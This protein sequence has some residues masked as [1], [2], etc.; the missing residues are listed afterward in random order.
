MIIYG[1]GGMWVCVLQVS[2]IKVVAIVLLRLNI[3]CDAGRRAVV[4]VRQVRLASNSKNKHGTSVTNHLPQIFFTLK[5]QHTA[6]LLSFLPATNAL[7][8]VGSK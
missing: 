5:I 7:F 6:E 1:Y 4:L 2:G 8:K 3:K